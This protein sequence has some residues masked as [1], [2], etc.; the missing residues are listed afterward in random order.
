MCPAGSRPFRVARINNK[1]EASWFRGSVACFQSTRVAVSVQHLFSHRPWPVSSIPCQRHSRS[2]EP[3][4]GKGGE[5]G[6]LSTKP[7]ARTS[8]IAR[9]L[10]SPSPTTGRAPWTPHKHGVLSVALRSLLARSLSRSVGSFK[11]FCLPGCWRAWRQ[12]SPRLPPRDGAR[13]V[14]ASCR[15]EMAVDTP[16]RVTRSSSSLAVVAGVGRWLQA[17]E[18]KTELPEIQ[19]SQLV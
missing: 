3:S 15:C 11:M 10:A 16:L 4:A 18:V 17:P 5:G 6:S 2:T 13:D 12:R 7:P 9:Q 19:R 8:R 1:E 14:V